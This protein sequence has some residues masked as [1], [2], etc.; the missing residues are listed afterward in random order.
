MVQ[1]GQ[2]GEVLSNGANGWRRRRVSR[3][4]AI[5]GAT[6]TVSKAHDLQL[7]LMAFLLGSLI[8]LALA[9]WAGAYNYVPLAAG[10]LLCGLALAGLGR[11]WDMANSQRS[12]NVH[13]T[14]TAGGTASSAAHRETHGTRQT[15]S[16]KEDEQRRRR[17]GRVALA[18]VGRPVIVIIFLAW[19]ILVG[20]LVWLS[21][22][23]IS[24]TV[25]SYPLLVE[26]ADSPQERAAGL[27]NR[28]SLPD[29]HGMLFIFDQVDHH[30]F[31]M[32]DTTIPLSIAFIDE[33]GRIVDIQDMHPL[34][35]NHHRAAVPALCALE[36]NQGWF[37][38]RNIRTGDTLTIPIYGGCTR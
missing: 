20:A 34:S 25:G 18:Y 11:L 16:Q 4:P 15:Q 28:D 24:V 21:H 2:Q 36:V 27:S 9:V 13:T 7:I 12:D 26:I 37:S 8:F 23:P 32:K 22:R 3:L 17:L 5:P 1:A 14:E 10:W 31:W 29:D 38:S 35:L 30:V 19:L 6:N 33:H